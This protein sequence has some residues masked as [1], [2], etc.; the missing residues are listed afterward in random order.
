MIIS[1][2][3]KK[4]YIHIPKNGG[5]SIAVAIEPFLKWNDILI[6]GSL[7]GESFQNVWS[8]RF[9]LYKH[10]TPREVKTVLGDQVYDGYTKF[11]TT[12]HPLSRFHSSFR[13][14]KKIIRENPEWYRQTAEFKINLK[15]NSVRDFLDSYY[16][17]SI[18]DFNKSRYSD[19]EK[20]FIPQSFFFEVNESRINKFLFFKLEDLVKD[21]SPLFSL[22]NISTLAALPCS[23]KNEIDDEI[24][25]SDVRARLK[26]IYFADY[27]N[28]SYESD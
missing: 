20:L 8:P 12:R 19:I 22:L 28:F 2:S 26:K 25:D 14:L 9:N 11:I 3:E 7:I 6:G 24:F 15:L 5:T 16:F 13:F 27:T 1:N 23:N 18:F 17:N 21:A 4:I 10:S